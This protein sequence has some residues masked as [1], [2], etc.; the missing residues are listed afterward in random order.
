MIR[1]T[2]YASVNLPVYVVGWSYD[3]PVARSVLCETERDIDRYF[4]AMMYLRF[5]V[6]TGQQ[7]VT[8][9]L[10]PIPGTVGIDVVDD[11][12]DLRLV[13]VTGK[14]VNFTAVPAP[15]IIE[16][17][18]RPDFSAHGYLPAYGKWL[19]EQ[20]VPFIGVR[21]PGGRQASA[22]AYGWVFSARYEG[23]IYNGMQLVLG[24]DQIQVTVP[25]RQ[26]LLF[27]R[28][29]KD[30]LEWIRSLNLDESCP[31]L[32]QPGSS[33]LPDG[34]VV[35]LTGGYSAPL[36]PAT[37]LALRTMWEP[38]LPGVVVVPIYLNYHAA[39]A[40]GMKMAMHRCCVV[41]QYEGSLESISN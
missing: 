20:G 2:R 13:S 30:Y 37:V 14:M 15:G 16:V 31:V 28:G 40:F 1:W 21:V 6:T 5:S 8:L 41:C 19:L 17:S 26:P 27:S 12:F 10:Q 32:F 23:S 18:F 22:S 38:E 4:G 24:Q 9:P 25:G 36:V 3:G 33:L 11:A 7:S 39:R 35:T 34:T 29:G